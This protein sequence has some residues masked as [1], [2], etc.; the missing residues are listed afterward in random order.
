MSK[1]SIFILIALCLS[2][3]PMF[4]QNKKKKNVAPTIGAI[5]QKTAGMDKRSGYFN[6]YW[7]EKKGEIWLEIDKLDQEFLYVNSL[8]AGV[9]SN[10][11]GL[12]RGQLGNERVVK[13]LKIG[14]KVLLVQPNYSYRAVSDNSEERLS[15]EEAFAKSVIA[16]F[17]VEAEQNDRVLVNLSNFLLRD[18]HNVIGRL[19]NTNQGNYKLDKSLSALYM[20]RTKNFPKN[21]EF[22]ALLTFTGEPRGGYIRS[23]TPTASNVTVRQHHSFIELPDDNYKP[24]KFDPRSGYFGIRYMDYATPI[25][26]NIVKRFISRHRL[27]KKDPTAQVSEPV[28]PIIYYLDRGAPEPIKSALIEGASWWNQAFETIGYKNAFQVKVLPEGADPLDVRYNVIQWVHRS[29]RGWSYGS[30]VQDPRTGEIIKGHVSLGSLRVRQDFLIAEGLL[31]PYETG[32][33]VSQEMQKMALARLRQLSAHEVGHTIGLSHNYISSVHG[34]ASVMDYPHPLVLINDNNQFDLSNA[35]DD[36]I[37]AWDKVAVAYGYQDFADNVDEDKALNKILD[38]AHTNGLKVISDADARPQG[39]A[40]PQSHLWDNGASAVD[41]LNR[42]MRVRKIALENF[43]E[44]N[45]KEGAPMA[46]LE[47]V[48]VPMYMFH[49]YQVEAAVKVVGGLDYSYALRGDDQLVTKTLSSEEQQKALEALLATL[50][51]ENLTIP[52]RILKLI[53]PRPVGYSRSRETF[54]SRTGLVFDPLSAAEAAADHTLTLLLNSQRATRLVQ[55]H[56]RD[57]QQPGLG[58][59]IDQLLNTTIKVK[60]KQGLQAEIQR[61]T[62]SLVLDKLI[63]LATNQST[64]YQ[65][66]AI[67]FTKL[68]NLENWMRQQMNKVSGESQKAHLNYGIYT[69]QNFKKNPENYKN[70]DTVSPPDG[71]PI[72]NGNIHYLNLGCDF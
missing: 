32:K 67:T 20:Q 71:S 5:E 36:K 57:S 68:D 56:A 6:F 23:V 55:F 42:V 62:G 64:T 13:F 61:L 31:A 69:I 17:K 47:E 41:E 63:K 19:K 9:G 48:L 39:S 43:S 22:E 33:A 49:R 46:T 28:E 15:V 38:E 53:P 1:S 60:Q 3:S 29:T 70:I 59:V 30:S 58:H 7:D 4:S 45:I 72:G 16:G 18:A 52:E 34:R 24:R 2:T 11:I 66:R 8:S 12:D 37:G 14:P 10:D 25:S 51:P 50:S 35:Y 40:H 44:D 26:E 65:V 27:E 54:A 21:S